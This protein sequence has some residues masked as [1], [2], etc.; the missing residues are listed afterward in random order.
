M[1]TQYQSELHQAGLSTSQALV[2][3]VLL[4]RGHLTVGILKRHLPYSRQMIYSLLDELIALELVEKIES[5]GSVTRFV[6]THP[7]NL[8]SLI[9]R[10]QKATESAEAALD[11]VLSDM[12]SSYN[13]QSGKPGVQFTEGLAGVET[14]LAATLE[15]KEETIYTYVDTESIERF[16]KDI[17]ATYVKKR[18]ARGI[19]KKIL[20]MDTP[21]ARK[22]A[23][24]AQTDDLTEIKLMGSGKI[25][26]VPAVIEIHNGRVSYITFTKGLLTTTTLHDQTI[27]TL[28]RFIF[29]SHWSCAA[30]PPEITV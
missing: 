21:L 20:M 14:V 29:E 17:N 16:V 27:Y 8:Q 19:K 11:N 12:T 6:V 18:R 3:E 22:K 2:Y 25:P 1:Q 26:A 9:T 13:I 4:Q 10:Q 23:S 7:S 24:A 30:T 15:H 5:K 28:H